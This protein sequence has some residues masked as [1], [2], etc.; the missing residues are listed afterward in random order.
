M[1]RS[2]SAGALAR[3]LALPFF[4]V[5]FPGTGS[6]LHAQ[7]VVASTSLAGA[8]ARAAGASE[9]RVLTPAETKHPPEYELKPSD[10]LKFEGASVVIYAG[11][12]KMVSRLL[13]TSKQK[14]LVAVQI[15]TATS[16]DNLIAQTRKVAKVLNREREEQLWEKRFLV[17]LATEKARLAPCEGKRAVVHLQAQPFS[18]WA[19]LSVVQ[20]VPPGEISFK[21]VTDAIAKQPDIVVDILH[22]PVARVIADNARC[23]YVQLINFPGIAGTV[24]LEDL[25]EYNTSQLAGAFR[26][27]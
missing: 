22:M 18:R 19:G 9:V 12:E 21:A 27:E 7:T 6:T 23:R 2:L 16:P 1:A 5:F 17:R 4:L 20:V 8:I 10:L 25:F 3:A 13:E 14:N 26:S 15:D 11:Y 24:T